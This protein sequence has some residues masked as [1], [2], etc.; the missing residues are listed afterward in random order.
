MVTFTIGQRIKCIRPD[1]PG[2]RGRIR[3]VEIYTVT[4][5]KRSDVT[6]KWMV[7]VHGV[8]GRFYQDRFVAASPSRK[9]NLPE[10]W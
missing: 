4:G 6:Q 2:D 7:I 5:V 3:K 9:R 1:H 10:W 8:T